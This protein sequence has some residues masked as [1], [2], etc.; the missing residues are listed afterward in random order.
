MD[1]RSRLLER[2]ET[3]R[4]IAER[5][6]EPR[7][8]QAL[9]TLADEYARQA[10]L[11]GK[12]SHEPNDGE[13]TDAGASAIG[14]QTALTILREF[15]RTRANLVGRGV[16]LADGKAGTIDRVFL[17]ELHGLR[18]SIE[19]HEGQWSISTVKFSEDM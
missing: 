7:T 3:C 9:R 10:E 11:V 14:Q 18:I 4:C 8:A 5:I 2:A 17:D 13:A 1:D 6:S 16:V 19:G 12:Q 15:E